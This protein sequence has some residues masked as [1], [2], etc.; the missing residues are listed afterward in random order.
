MNIVL[1]ESASA[2]KDKSVF[3]WSGIFSSYD[4]IAMADKI[5]K[6]W[7]VRQRLDPSIRGKIKYW[8]EH[9]W[10]FCLVDVRMASDNILRSDVG[11]ALSST[12]WTDGSVFVEVLQAALKVAGTFKDASGT[13]PSNA[14]REGPPVVEESTASSSSTPPT[15]W[16]YHRA[17]SPTLRMLLLH[18]LCVSCTHVRWWSRAEQH[19]TST[20]TRQYS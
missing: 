18:V 4:P 13:M 10:T 12:F 15:T 5:Q 14:H 2:D 1:V 19:A 17:S 6:L 3:Q 7:V 16:S 8:T 20:A 9:I 11:H